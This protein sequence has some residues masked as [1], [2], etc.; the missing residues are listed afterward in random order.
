MTAF[1]SWRD[2]CS[3]AA[4]ADEN[5]DVRLI[6]PVM[7]WDALVNLAFDRSGLRAPIAAG[8]APPD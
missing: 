3:P 8:D 5:G 7:D 1:D 6:V 2:A 4:T